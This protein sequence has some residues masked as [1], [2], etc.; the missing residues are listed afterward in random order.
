LSCTRPSFGRPLRGK[1]E[2]G[3]AGDEAREAG[4]EEGRE[5]AG[6]EG[7]E[8]GSEEEGKEGREYGGGTTFDFLIVLRR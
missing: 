2:I 4:E 5:E 8:E 1:R 6:E 7:S 3:K